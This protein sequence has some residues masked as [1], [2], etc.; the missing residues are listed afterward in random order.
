M[1]NI[2]EIHTTYGLEDYMIELVGANMGKTRSKQSEFNWLKKQYKAF[3]K[4]NCCFSEKEFVR[5]YYNACFY[6]YED[7][8]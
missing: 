6:L 4:S 3:K 8:D 2:E 7:E 1:L 5:A